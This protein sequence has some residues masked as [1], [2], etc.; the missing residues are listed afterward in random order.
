MRE[1]SVQEH[2]ASIIRFS[3]L[4]T[5]EKYFGEKAQCFVKLDII[6]YAREILIKA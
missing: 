3:F 6:L 4:L 5:G 2:N 1:M